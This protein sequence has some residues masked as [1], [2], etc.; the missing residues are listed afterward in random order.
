[1][2]YGVFNFL[3]VRLPILILIF[4]MAKGQCLISEDP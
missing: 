3:L 1:M 2:C 4:L